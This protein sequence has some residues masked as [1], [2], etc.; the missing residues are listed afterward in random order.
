VDGCS[1][2]YAGHYLER[3]RFHL[4]V[5]DTS[6]TQ[7][8]YDALRIL[9]GVQPR[10]V[11]DS[12]LIVHEVEYGF[13][14]L[15]TWYDRM[16][17]GGVWIVGAVTSSGIDERDNLITVSLADRNFARGTEREIRRVL[18]RLRIPQ[19]VVRVEYGVVVEPW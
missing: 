14:Q 6:R 10:R 11:S 7:A 19:R 4:L 8:V 13:R 2:W 1:G 9:Y 5:T 16:L 15:K 18:R 3:G 12:N 17:Q